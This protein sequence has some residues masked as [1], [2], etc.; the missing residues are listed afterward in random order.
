MPSYILRTID[1]ALWADV[2]TRAD[3]DGLPLRQVILALLRHYA[4]GKV[5]LAASVKAKTVD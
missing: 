4:D 3:S 5:R 1:P 2:K